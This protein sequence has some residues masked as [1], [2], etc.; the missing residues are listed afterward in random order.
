MHTFLHRRPMIVE[1]QGD[2]IS[3]RMGSTRRDLFPPW[4]VG[5]WSR[6]LWKR[7]KMEL[8]VTRLGYLPEL[9]RSQGSSASGV[10]MPPR[11]LEGQMHALSSRIAFSIQGG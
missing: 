6:L 4:K 3:R 9:R 5:S 8:S 10:E 7:G 2:D 1:Q 11:M